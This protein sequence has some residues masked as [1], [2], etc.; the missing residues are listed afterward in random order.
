MTSK[1][2][3]VG[4]GGTTRADSTTQRSLELALTLCE[5]RGADTIS[6]VGA[7]LELEAY[8]PST[9]VRSP[10]AQYLVECLRRADGVIIA[11]PSYHGSVSGLIKNALDYTEELRD[12]PAPYLANRAVG[13]IVCADGAQAIG[14]TLVALRSIVHALRGWPT[15]YAAAVDASSRP[16]DGAGRL[17]QPQVAAQIAIVADQVVEFASMKRAWGQRPNP[18]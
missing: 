2:L 12:D 1:P 3:I 6:V 7:Q 5:Q 9:G 8:D 11:T 18:A 10:A 16:F 17:Q 15:P 4:I 13:A 14:S